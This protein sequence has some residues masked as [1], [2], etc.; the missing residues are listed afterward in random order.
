MVELLLTPLTS[1]ILDPL[2]L[3]TSGDWATGIHARMVGMLCIG[4]APISGLDRLQL[5]NLSAAV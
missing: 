5:L 2:L 3:Q 1:Q 4:T